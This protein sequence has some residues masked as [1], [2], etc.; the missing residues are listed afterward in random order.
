[1][2]NR[3]ALVSTVGAVAVVAGLSGNAAATDEE[4]ICRNAVQGKV[5]WDTAGSKNWNPENVKNLCRG[6]ADHEATIACFSGKIS[7]GQGWKAAIDGCSWQ[8]PRAAKDLGMTVHRTGDEPG[9]KKVVP[10]KADR[11]FQGN[12]VCTTR[13]VDISDSFDT[14]F[15]GKS[16]PLRKALLPGTVFFLNDVL[17]GS[18]T[19]I[20]NRARRDYRIYVA[21]NDRTGRRTGS[22][23]VGWSEGK[24]AARG[25]DTLFRDVDGTQSSVNSAIASIVTARPYNGNYGSSFSVE[26]IHSNA[27]L[28]IALDAAASYNGFDMK[29]TFNFDENNKESKI[30]GQFLQ[31]YYAVHVDTGIE[32]YTAKSFFYDEEAEALA[33]QQVERGPLVYI[34]SVVYGRAAYFFTETKES[35]LSVEATLH[36]AYSGAAEAEGNVA[37]DYK[38]HFK[39]DKLQVVSIGGGNEDGAAV[40]TLEDFKEL[41][42]R[43]PPQDGL[44]AAISYVLR[45]VDDGSLAAVNVNTNYPQRDCAKLKNK[46]RVGISDV[47]VNSADDEGA[48]DNRIEIEGSIYVGVTYDKFDKK[49]GQMKPFTPILEVSFNGVK[50]PSS[51]QLLQIKTGTIGDTPGDR[52]TVNRY[53][54]FEIPDDPETPEVNEAKEAVFTIETSGFIE[55]DNGPDHL[56]NPDDK[57]SPVN[58]DDAVRKISLAK[59]EEDTS[60]R[61]GD[62]CPRFFRIRGEDVDDLDADIKV[63]FF[64]KPVD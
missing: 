7:E 47:I 28:N 61:A 59:L 21:F 49:S 36:A 12:L 54:D 34:D 22:N 24:E 18:F 52:V 40:D 57:L 31:R 29:S 37:T 35:D 30:V 5:A 51:K 44:G 19:P 15:V 43:A 16:E 8:V 50:I 13:N 27:Q 2:R 45:F 56:T 38:N 14:N 26:E 62:D 64:I 4:N 55:V 58:R 32:G 17:S 60:A 46:I 20:G 3:I 9:P 39:S 33:A 63:C 48:A 10:P 23:D 41:I 53:L 6:T 11:T 25:D 1:M 42:N